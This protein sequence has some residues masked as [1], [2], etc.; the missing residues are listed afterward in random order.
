MPIKTV[1]DIDV[2]SKRVLLRVDFNVPMEKSG[3]GIRD[4][5]RIRVC[6]PTIRYLL[7]HHAKVIIC[8]HLGRPKGKIDETLRMTPVARRLSE[9][10]GQP[11]K[12]L[13]ECVGPEVEKVVSSMNDG[14]VVLLENLRFYPGEEKNDPEFAKGLAR[15]ADVFVNDAFG[16]SH[17]AHA[18]VVGVTNYLPSVAGFLMEKEVTSLGGLLEKPERPFAA[19]IGGAKVS[20]K[21]DVLDN[22]VP[23]VD[24]LIIGGGMTA[25]FL[26]SRGNRVGKSLV[27][28]DKIQYVRDLS[29][30]AKSHDVRLLLPT[31]VVVSPS[32][33]GTSE[34][35]TVSVSDIPDGWFIGDIGPQTIAEYTGALSGCKTVFWNGPMGVF[36][37]EQF[38]TGTREIASTIARLDAVKVVGGGSTVEAVTRLGVADQMTHVSTGGGATLEFISG[39]QLPGVKAL[40]ENRLEVP[41]V[42]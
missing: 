12:S 9:L 16:A 21:L 10:L 22:I 7:D 1:N 4:D 18:S 6:L 33:D 30:Q 35:R 19:V 41:A 3:G 5:T 2:T 13:K 26:K 37:V 11:V 36:E 42:R 31:D 14:D 23:D 27:E 25:T 39:K 32:L 34:S 8:S 17:R 28:D 15:L 38:A 29:E 40:E 24:V 20:D